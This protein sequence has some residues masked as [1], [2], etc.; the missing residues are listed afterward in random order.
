MPV[1]KP[2]LYAG[3]GSRRTPGAIMT[4]MRK[5]AARLAEQG[6]FL[7]SGGA[8]GADEAFISGTPPNRRRVYLPWPDYNGYYGPYHFLRSDPAAP[9]A[10]AKT[11]PPT[12]K[13]TTA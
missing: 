12:R 13:R 7:R 5:L 6:W 11:Q 9:S 8:S 10:P 1:D 2:M 3:I 4:T